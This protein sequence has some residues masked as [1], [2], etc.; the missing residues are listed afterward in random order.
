[1][2]DCSCPPARWLTRLVSGGLLLGLAACA[3]P[4]PDVLATYEGGEVTVEELDDVLRALPEGQRQQ[5]EGESFDAWLA[6]QIGIRA[7]EE[8]ILAHARE[9]GLEDDP[10]I[11]L[12]ARGSVAQ[13]IAARYVQQRCPPQEVDEA[14]VREAYETQVPQEPE[15]W[16][17]L[18]HIY[19]RVPASADAARR[20]AARRDLETV[21]A[22]VL[23]GGSFIELARQHSDSKTADEGGLIGRI[24]RHAPIE[25]AVLAAAWALEDGEVSEVVAV[26][27]GFHLLYRE[28]SGVKAVQPFAEARLG[29]ERTLKA[30]QQQACGDEILTTLSAETPFELHAERL[31]DDD[32]EAVIFE[33]GDES[34]TRRALDDL[35]PQSDSKNAASRLQ[36]VLRQ[37]YQALLLATHAEAEGMVSAAE[38]EAAEARLRQQLML[39]RQWLE[40]RRAQIAAKP[41]SEL[42]A[43]YEAHQ[44]QLRTPMVLDLGLILVLEEGGRRASFEQ[45]HRIRRRLVAGE[46]FGS[47]AEET[48]Q[49]ASSAAEGRL[50]PLPLPS[51]RPL[52]GQEGLPVAMQLAVDE[53]SEPI[54][55]GT[56]AQP[57]YAL[58]KLFGRQEPRA[59]P[60]EAV[61][62]RV[63]E[64]MAREEVI[65]LNRA[66]RETR[67]AESGFH[68]HDHAL[69]AYVQKLQG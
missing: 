45:A 10:A 7:L 53:V 62:E 3:A 55:L 68:V 23:E 16:I 19:K 28:E 43:Y 61:R 51:L 57:A 46:P 22:E 25:A 9:R 27:N 4:D 12:R 30:Q 69:E 64:A 49:H 36:P 31:A 13:G 29:I 38:R 11:A 8:I 40:E 2:M 6:D 21:R 14:E 63:V 50:G 1:M 42:R 60:F 48:S 18:R 33:L 17:L 37:L 47:V 35:L 34:F 66:L 58:L 39:E 15:P 20:N 67:L 59:Q 26:A 32:P 5:A 44:E 52:L 65:E 24:S 54:F 56:A 41:E